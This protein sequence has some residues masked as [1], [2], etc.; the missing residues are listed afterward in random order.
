MSILVTTKLFIQWLNIYWAPTVCPGSFG[1]EGSQ[2][3]HNDTNRWLTSS[4]EVHWVFWRGV[5]I[6]LQWCSVA[7]CYQPMPCPH[8]WGPEAQA[9]CRGSPAKRK[10]ASP[11]GRLPLKPPTRCMFGEK[12]E[13]M[14]FLSTPWRGK[15]QVWGAWVS[16]YLLGFLGSCLLSWL[17]SWLPHGRC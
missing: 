12:E 4:G 2:Q 3:T 16:R 17:P 13:L 14:A 6:H 5:Q 1:R 9:P 8:I 10:M 11:P 7:A 15:K